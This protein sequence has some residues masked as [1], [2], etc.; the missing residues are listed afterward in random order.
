M[1]YGYFSLGN[2]VRLCLRPVEAISVLDTCAVSS[3]MLIGTVTSIVNREVGGSNPPI[4][5]AF[6]VAQLDRAL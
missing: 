5:L 3:A 1:Q 4:K 6:D 2:A